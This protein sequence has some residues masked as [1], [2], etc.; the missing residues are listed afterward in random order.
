MQ[1]I[2]GRVDCKDC[3]VSL[4]LAKGCN[5]S[6]ANHL[7]AVKLNNCRGS[8]NCSNRLINNQ[9]MVWIMQVTILSLTLRSFTIH[10]Q[11]SKRLYMSASACSRQTNEDSWRSKTRCHRKRIKTDKQCLGSLHANVF[12]AKV[13]DRRTASAFVKKSPAAG[14]AWFKNRCS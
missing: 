2:N 6:S 9:L 12:T 4:L 7:L 8:S 3:F 5:C 13:H 1:G 11:I 10:K 14:N